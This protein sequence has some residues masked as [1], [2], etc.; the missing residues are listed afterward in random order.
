M[1]DDV[2]RHDLGKGVVPVEARAVGFRFVERQ[3]CRRAVREGS[4]EGVLDVAWH[5]SGDDVCVRRNGGEWF[6]GVLLG[7]GWCPV[8]QERRR[9][10]G[11]G[12]VVA[13]RGVVALCKRE[14]RHG[15]C[16]R[17]EQYRCDDV[18]QAGLGLVEDEGGEVRACG[19]KRIESGVASAGFGDVEIDQG[20]ND[21]AVAGMHDR[22][23][24]VVAASVVDEIAGGEV[25]AP[26]VECRVR[27]VDVAECV[28]LVDIEEPVAGLGVDALERSGGLGARARTVR[29]RDVRPAGGD[30]VDRMHEGRG[31]VVAMEGDFEAHRRRV[32]CG[33]FGLDEFGEWCE[34]SEGRCGVVVES[35][36]LGGAIQ[37]GDGAAGQRERFD[38]AGAGVEEWERGK[39]AR[40]RMDRRG[41]DGLAVVSD[42]HGRS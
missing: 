25:F 42:G 15:C 16:D 23:I 37:Y 2:G 26:L 34:P 39:A 12:D 22:E 21:A 38:V 4:R 11:I 8:A 36:A 40:V 28:H 13:H 18:V 24:C 14:R 27:G 10:W 7:T 35:H 19:G 29:E 1:H 9:G 3:V 31:G 41:D 30:A 5:A 20:V 6:G 32:V 17:A 33:V